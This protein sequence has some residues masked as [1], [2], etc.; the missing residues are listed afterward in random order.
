M[1]EWRSAQPAAARRLEEALALATGAPLRVEIARELAT[2]RWK[3]GELE[4]AIALLDGAI[5]RATGER[6]RHE[7]EADRAVFASLSAP[8]QPLSGLDAAERLAG[9]T[10]AERRLL[11]A[12]AFH[13]M[14]WG[15]TTGA[16]VG[17]LAERALAGGRLLED[18][19]PGHP[20]VLAVLS[21]LQVV[22]RDAQ[23]EALI[24]TARPE[25]PVEAAVL[26]ALRGRLDLFRGDLRAAE[27]TTR[28]VLA[29]AGDAGLTH[30]HRFA[31]PSLALVLV[32]R[33]DLDGAEAELARAGGPPKDNTFWLF[34]QARAAL[35]RA[36]G[37]FA[38]A[39]AD[40]ARAQRQRSGE[41]GASVLGGAILA[42]ALHAVGETAEAERL[43][44]AS[45]AHA[46]RWGVPSTLGMALRAQGL[47]TGEVERLQAAVAALAP[48]PRRL[49]HARALVDLGAALRRA[50]RRAEAREPLAA[51][52]DLAQRCGATSLAARAREEL[53]ACGARPRRL[54][55]SGVDALTPS[56]LRVAQL[57]AAGR[58]NREIAQTLFVTRKT[59]ETH[60]GGVYRKLGVNAR[61]QL[62]PKLQDPPP[63]ANRPAGQEAVAS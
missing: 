63:D 58:S 23:V 45:V 19:G 57:A 17:R 27:A 54:L 1:A 33:G 4:P 46:R 40:A 62:G 13:R 8:E 49:E 22:E 51:G 32:E 41:G 53:V 48:T 6:E 31:L 29:V 24:A 61:E 52:M 34:L 36:Q 39:A 15:A 28:E 7:L 2:L 12:L 42:L 50:N 35:R 43:A 47:V 18:V 44:A 11:A 21:A 9:D 14:I 5:A 37:R 3:Q 38:E 55:R 16:E 10:P 59:V 20:S 30:V 25:A 26:R 60:L 56:E